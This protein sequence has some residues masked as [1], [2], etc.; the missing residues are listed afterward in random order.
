MKA[1]E[2]AECWKA[3]AKEFA[4]SKST[5]IERSCPL[6]ES[7]IA[8]KCTSNAAGESTDDWFWTKV[9]AVASYVRNVSMSA[10]DGLK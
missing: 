1:S 3:T 10:I 5:F 2:K 9:L 4:T 6:S 8:R 7:T